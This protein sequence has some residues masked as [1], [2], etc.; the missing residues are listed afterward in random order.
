VSAS[1][2]GVSQAIIDNGALNLAGAKTTVVLNGSISGS[3]ALNVQN[4][5]NATVAAHGPPS[6]FETACALN[7]RS[8]P[9]ASR[10]ARASSP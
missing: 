2:T 7:L 9:G 4:S 6:W 10:R 5:T 3:G 1:Y 8:I